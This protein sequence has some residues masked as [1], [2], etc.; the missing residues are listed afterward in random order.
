MN[1]FPR[2]RKPFGRFYSWWSASINPEL[3]SKLEKRSLYL[4]SMGK[5]QRLD[6]FWAKN[7]K[8]QGV[9][10]CPILTGSTS[11]SSL[12]TPTVLVW[13]CYWWQKNCVFMSTLGTKNSGLALTEKQLPDVVLWWD[14]YGVDCYEL[15]P[16][17]VPIIAEVYCQ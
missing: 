5:V 16:R 11:F 2:S 1:D 6:V 14:K 9:T 17:N 10:I 13:D 8:N 12:T 15:L 3:A 4:H 7:N